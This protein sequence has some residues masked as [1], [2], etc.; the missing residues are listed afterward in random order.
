M[1]TDLT[2]SGLIVGFMQRE[3]N[4]WADMVNASIPFWWVRTFSG[5]MMITGLLCGAYNMWMTARSNRE[6]V[7]DAHYIAAEA[8]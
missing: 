4:P 1:F 2:I 7:E 3:L 8:D 6:Y 5:G